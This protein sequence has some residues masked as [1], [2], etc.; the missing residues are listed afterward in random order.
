[1]CMYDVLTKK[2]MAKRTTL[3]T[4]KPQFPLSVMWIELPY[5]NPLTAKF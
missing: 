4:G 2:E 5:V 1:M 3:L